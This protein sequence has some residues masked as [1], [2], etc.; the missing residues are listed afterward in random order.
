MKP[1]MNTDKHGSKPKIFRGLE[2]NF[3]HSPEGVAHSGGRA[4][5]T[6]STLEAC[7]PRGG[8]LVAATPR[9]VNP[10]NP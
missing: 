5:N 8:T 1:Q 9:R 4:S 10:S 7:A 3:P 6:Q 2:R